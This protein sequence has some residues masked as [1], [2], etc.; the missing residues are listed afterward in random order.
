MVILGVTIY[1]A[2]RYYQE[3]AK[4]NKVYIEEEDGNVQKLKELTGPLRSRIQ[5]ESNIF[6]AGESKYYDEDEDD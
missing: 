1:A 2:R 6:E 4:L 3:K 5:P